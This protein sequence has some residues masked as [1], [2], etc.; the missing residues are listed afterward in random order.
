MNVIIWQDLQQR[1]RDTLLKSKLMLV[2]GVLERKN[3]VTHIIAGHL[4][5]QSEQ[6]AGFMLPSRDF[7]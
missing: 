5:D 4:Q 7:H 3:S 6:L 2:K 1:C